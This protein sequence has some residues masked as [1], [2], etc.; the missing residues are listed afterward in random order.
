MIIDTH[1][2]ARLFKLESHV[3]REAKAAA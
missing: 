2:H 1:I 3:Q